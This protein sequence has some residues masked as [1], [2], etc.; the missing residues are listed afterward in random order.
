MGNKQIYDKIAQQLKQKILTGDLKPGYPLPSERELAQSLGVSRGSL[1]KAFIELEKIGLL[2][3]IPGK[4]RIVRPLGDKGVQLEKG[5]ILDLIEARLYIE[6]VIASL[7]AERATPY[8]LTQLKNILIETEKH[9]DD[10]KKR[11]Q[12]D[13]EFHLAVARCTHNFIFI[14]LVKDYFGLLMNV[15]EKIYPVLTDKTSFI[16][17]HQ[18]IYKHILNKDPQQAKRWAEKHLKRI[19]SMLKEGLI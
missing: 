17:E 2:E 7:A 3:N 11:A 14:N 19:I 16:K 5:A 6:P 13:C 12:K 10:L 1:R 9:L 15:H 18:Q 4:G 8:E